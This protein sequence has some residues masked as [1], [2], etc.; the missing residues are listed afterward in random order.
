MD[1]YLVEE[2]SAP[3]QDEIDYAVDDEGS[4][5]DD[6]LDDNR[7]DGLD[8]QNQAIEDADGKPLSRKEFRLRA[9]QAQQLNDAV[10]A[11]DG[12]TKLCLADQNQV[13]SVLIRRS[14]QTWD[15]AKQL[16]TM[17][18]T[19]RRAAEGRKESLGTLANL[20][21]RLYDLKEVINTKGDAEDSS[22]EGKSDDETA[23]KE[24][25]EMAMAHIRRGQERKRIIAD[26]EVDAEVAM[27]EVGEANTAL[28]PHCGRIKLKD[29]I[30]KHVQAC[31]LEKERQR[32]RQQQQQDHLANSH[33]QGQG[34]KGQV[35]LAVSKYR[36]LELRA[37]E[38]ARERLE[39]VDQGKRKSFLATVVICP[40]CGKG[41]LA[42]HMQSHLRRC[43]EQQRIQLFMS[44][45]REA[46]KMQDPQKRKLQEQADELG[47]MV[48]L[49]PQNLSIVTLTSN[50]IELR[51]EPPIFSGG[52]NVNI[53]DYIIEYAVQKTIFKDKRSIVQETEQTPVSTSRFCALV[54]VNSGHYILK[55]LRASTTYARIR[56]RAKNKVGLSAPSNEVGP[57]ATD[58]AVQPSP[59]LHFM[60][61]RVTAEALTF[62]WSE[63]ESDGGA[64][65]GILRYEVEYEMRAKSS[66]KADAELTRMKSVVNYPCLCF[67]LDGLSGLT[68]VWGVKVHAVAEAV[69]HS[70]ELVELRSK[71]SNVLKEVTTLEPE[72]D[73]ALRTEIRRV[74]LAQ[75]RQVDSA[76]YSGVM[77]RYERE[78]LIAKL[79]ADLLTMQT[80][81]ARRARP[82]RK[83]WTAFPT[84]L[85]YKG[86]NLNL[87][88][89]SV[90]TA[91]RRNKLHRDGARRSIKEA[92]EV[93]GMPEALRR[94]RQ[95]LFRIQ[96]HEDE[97][98]SLEHERSECILRRSVLSRALD[99]EERRVSLLHAEL[100]RATAH[101]GKFIDSSAMHGRMQRFHTVSFRE[102]L[103]EEIRSNNVHLSEGKREQIGIERKL[104]EL[105]TR[106]DVVTDALKDR[107]ARMALF[108]R[109]M[110]KREKALERVR[111]WRDRILYDLFQ[112]WSRV[113]RAARQQRGRS[114]RFLMRM[115][116][117]DLY[118]AWF[119]WTAFVQHEVLKEARLRE[120]SGTGSALLEQARVDRADLQGGAAEVL[121]K[122]RGTAEDLADVKRTEAQR[123]DQAK[124]AFFNAKESEFRQH[125][126]DHP[127]EY[128]QHLV[129]LKQGQ[130][131]LDMGHHHEA[132]ACFTRFVHEQS[133]RISSV[134]TAWDDFKETRQEVEQRL[135]KRRGDLLAH[136]ECYYGI[137]QCMQALHKVD[138]AMVNFD[139]MRSLACEAKSHRLEGLALLG[140][141]QCNM[142]RSAHKAAIDYADRA[143]FIFEDLNDR[144]HQALACRQLQR[145]YT[146]M[147]DEENSKAFE[148]RADTLELELESKVT[149]TFAKIAE[150]ER[151][152]VSVTAERS[153]VIELEVVSAMV[154]DLRLKIEEN[155]NKVETILAEAKKISRLYNSDM[156]R[157]KDI[158]AQLQVVDECKEEELDSDLVHGILQRFK[159]QQLKNN[160][161]NEADRLE[162]EMERCQE[163][164]R[165]AE[166][167]AS[168]AQDDMQGLEQDLAIEL[169]TLMRKTMR[170][171]QQFRYVA[172][173]TANVRSRNVS[174]MAT[175]GVERLAACIR[176]SIYIF[177][178][179]D[180]ALLGVHYGSKIPLPLRFE[181]KRKKDPS[182]EIPGHHG[183][184]T[185]LAYAE[186]RIISG[187]VD[188]M[189]R[190][191]QDRRPFKCELL[192]S[193]HEATIWSL[194]ADAVKLV[195]GDAAHCVR[196]WSLKQ[197]GICVRII[198]AL[199]NRAVTCI[200]VDHYAMATAGPDLEVRVWPYALDPGAGSDPK[201]N[202]KRFIGHDCPISC[203]ILSAT[204]L[205]SGGE[206]GRIFIWD[207]ASVTRLHI[208][209]GHNAPIRSL[210]ADATKLVSASLDA[211]ICVFDV[212]SGN[213]LLT[214]RGHED[215]ILAMQF[216]SWRILSASTDGTMRYWFWSGDKNEVLPTQDK[217]HVLQK[218]E[219]LA[220][221]EKLYGVPTKKLMLWNN[222]KDVG[223]TLYVGMRLIVQKAGATSTGSFAQ[224]PR[225]EATLRRKPLAEFSSSK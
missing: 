63:P 209:V 11:Y 142:V 188:R 190:V 202:G 42:S 38:R 77:Q 52:H 216:D 64:P 58:Y 195:S 107:R 27:L 100:D 199:H 55:G 192:L 160:L 9:L 147:Y 166:T 119:T 134:R 126:H 168:N 86:F 179:R 210:Q 24:L 106:M 197:N 154:P 87:R 177:D 117:R 56:V 131:H 6:E 76:A 132:L 149:N 13:Q 133:A 137:A 138:R 118:R 129:A 115:Q 120:V 167:R 25:Q 8:G 191:W 189:I 90:R 200:A 62:V 14:E 205:I 69:N 17:E 185:A 23:H 61:A 161:E 22:K 165:R 194:W 91:V 98:K 74:T 128:A 214:L 213:R 151:K 18:T 36:E 7:Q 183:S 186:R 156:K 224:A 103:E 136:C 82:S 121:L 47:A 176:N 97:L 49:P 135:E 67:V 71:P 206:D 114:S 143:L 180:G 5:T 34:A 81:Q 127:E 12:V 141:S 4:N 148:E 116:H 220:S 101:K 105:R 104:Q 93:L 109:E 19:V 44:K 28:C 217:L 96:K 40:E 144:P 41:V 66:G 157:L 170:E 111:S 201:A 171:R 122:L 43:R 204:E 223:R 45:Q 108:E 54:P 79:N 26:A 123:K 65:G 92:K 208:C 174:G 68:K 16:R 152:L 139:R 51:W 113:A 88:R 158:R 37:Q 31:K 162:R 153:Q 70:G 53:Y 159:V 84:D 78:D 80:A 163:A 30:E 196:V 99:V 140:I 73:E 215:K 178:L 198:P 169:G 94:R 184:I 222:L 48:P 59:P 72:R 221:L 21:Q 125:I 2:G 95:F 89:E 15:I 145:A 150:A 212:S 85:L 211:T 182:L 173:N 1:A 83:I 164:S 124:S 155:R 203:V 181:A 32:S 10:R 110:A 29:F 207:V 130:A 39:A 102:A 33:G 60:V 20:E 57:V 3:G 50:T 46:S 219:T 75:S 175:G 187:G 146:D 193:G 35:N 172:L 218:G 112:H 225:E